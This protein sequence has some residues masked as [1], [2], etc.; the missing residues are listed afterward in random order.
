MAGAG[1]RSSGPEWVASVHVEEEPALA[2]EIQERVSRGSGERPISISDLLAPRRAFWRRIGPPAPIPEERRGAMESGRSW[3][4][5]LAEAL[6]DEGA[7][8]VRVR[9]DGIAG[10]IDLLADVPVEL[11]TG[12]AAG[13]DRIID[14]RPDHVEQIAM[15][16]ALTASPGARIVTLSP[17]SEGSPSVQAVDLSVPGHVTVLEVM[18]RRAQAIRSA[19]RDGKPV[20][21]PACR[22]FGRRCEFQEAGRC[23]CTG[24]EPVSDRGILDQVAHVAPRPDIEERWSSAL[25][26]LGPGAERATTPRFRDLIYPRRAYFEQTATAGSPATIAPPEAPAAGP[27]LYDRIVEA[28]EGGPVGEVARLPPRA[29]GPEEEVP[30][31]RGLPFLV[32]SSRAWNRLRPAEAIGRFPQYALELGFRCATTGTDEGRV[33]LAYERAEKESDRFEVLRYRFSPPGV[34]RELWKESDERL[35]AAIA[36]GTPASLPPCPGWM[37]EGCPYRVSCGCGG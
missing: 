4:A 6:P 31:F 12:S 33:I 8:E 15:Y 32:R 22:W 34:F 14:L 35:R 9:R 37:Y 7:F 30:G 16:C 24:E 26:A 21:L 11:K 2:Q 20:G 10:R 36:G 28:V 3:H 18:R 19:V 17:G 5:R 27:T 13:V 25:R 1:P 23:D 29:I